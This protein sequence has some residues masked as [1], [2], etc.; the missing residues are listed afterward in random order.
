[1]T[2]WV[3]KPTPSSVAGNSPKDSI[4]L[5]PKDSIDPSNKNIDPIL[6]DSS[7]QAQPTS[8]IEALLNNRSN[9][10]LSAP[11][12][13]SKPTLASKAK[14]K[15]QFKEINKAIISVTS[16][17]TKK[18]KKILCSK[19]Q[20]MFWPICMCSTCFRGTKL[21]RLSNLPVM[22]LLFLLQNLLFGRVPHHQRAFTDIKVEFTYPG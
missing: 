14:A 18:A 10:Y 17:Y 2:N 13:K 16:L 6:L 20:L 22:Q 4:N 15:A 8:E 11:K 5:D 9:Q 1:M 7:V 3:T 12:S 19:F 21:L